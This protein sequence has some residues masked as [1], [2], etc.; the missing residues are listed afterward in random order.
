VDPGILFVIFEPPF[1][2][3]FAVE[4]KIALLFVFVNDDLLFITRYSLDFTNAVFVEYGA[5]PRWVI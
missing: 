1:H 4:V 5:G 3:K 2:S